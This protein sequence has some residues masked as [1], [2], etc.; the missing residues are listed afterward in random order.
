MKLKIVGW[1]LAAFIAFCAIGLFSDNS[2]FGGI[3][4]LFLAFMTTPIGYTRGAKQKEKPPYG[5]GAHIGSTSFLAFCALIYF[6]SVNKDEEKIEGATNDQNAPNVTEEYILSG[7]AKGYRIISAK[8]SSIPNR[9][10]ISIQIIPDEVLEGPGDYVYT[11]IEAAKN[12]QKDSQA[13]VVSAYLEMNEIT[14]G[15]GKWL[16]M[17]HYIPDGKGFSG[18]DE[19]PAWDLMVKT[20]KIDQNYIDIHSLWELEKVAFQDQDGLINEEKLKAHLEKKLGIEKGTFTLPYTDIQ[21]ATYGG[22]SY[23]VQGTKS[24]QSVP[25]PSDPCDRDAICY[26]NK[27]YGV[28]ASR[29]QHKIEKIA[30][31]DYEWTDG[32]FEMKFSRAG[33]KEQKHKI[34]NI[35]GDKLKLQNGFGAWQNYI[36]ICTYDGENEIALEV[37]AEP[38]RF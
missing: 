6:V 13:K 31:Y 3:T 35:A 14:A 8:D 34:I 12:A 20:D 32:V 30:K 27:V 9:R 19:T 18:S 4:L 22:G 38:G 5:Y 37:N 29:C 23:E 11:V 7:A 15:R 26:M 25:L 10:R 28:A 36:Y 21:K 24:L 17:A 1:L 16:S 2:F 33:W